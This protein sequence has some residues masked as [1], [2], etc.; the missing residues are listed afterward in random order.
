[1]ANEFAEYLVELRGRAE[2]E[3]ATKSMTPERA[4]RSHYMEGD[5]DHFQRQSVREGR[6]EWSGNT[7]IDRSW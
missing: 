2:I 3:S 1:M 4:V 7:W 6:S 5:P